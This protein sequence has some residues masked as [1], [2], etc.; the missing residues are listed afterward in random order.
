MCRPN[1]RAAFSLY[2][3]VWTQVPKGG[4]AGY[5][6]R[7]IVPCTIFSMDI[8]DKVAQQYIDAKR[9]WLSKRPDPAGQ[10]ILQHL[11]NPEGKVL[12]DIG[13]GT[14]DEA[15]KYEQM[16]FASVQGI[17]PSGEML[18]EA[19]SKVKHPKNFRIGSYEQTGG[20]DQS[21]DVAVGL[22]SFHY[23]ENL[24]NGYREVAR[25]LKSGGSFIF[26]VRHPFSDLSEPEWFTRNG[27]GYVKPIV[28]EKVSIEHP[29]HSM[30]EYFSSTFLELFE[31]VAFKEWSNPGIKTKQN[32]PFLFGIVARKR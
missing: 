3:L 9:E 30:E 17:D 7:K 22:Y 20:T 8:Y 16:G 15:V 21:V 32:L 31:V 10:F 12:L 23:T 24:D 5:H 18:K 6:L 13:C 25:I 4:T 28:Y 14:G 11:D 2:F 29:F 1:Q 26:A 19:A 27:I